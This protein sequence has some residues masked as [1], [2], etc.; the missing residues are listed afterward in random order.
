MC[1]VRR[2][3]NCRDVLAF[4]WSTTLNTLRSTLD[5]RYERYITKYDTCMLSLDASRYE[6]YIKCSIFRTLCECLLLR[7]QCIV[8]IGLV[9]TVW[10]LVLRVWGCRRKTRLVY[11]SLQQD[12]GQ[13]TA[14]PTAVERQ[15]AER[16]LVAVLLCPLALRTL[17]GSG[18]RVW[19]SCFGASVR[20]LA[21]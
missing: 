11:D 4:K 21:V 15:D 1:L 17:H 9:S 16:R 19:G 2:R 10:G 13:C 12:C 7:A 20:D 6:R 18:S 14:D 3:E 8:K 5:A